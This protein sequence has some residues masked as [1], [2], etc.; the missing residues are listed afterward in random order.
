MEITNHKLV[1]TTPKPS[2][3]K[4]S[5]G[6]LVGPPPPPPPFEVVADAAAA[7]VDEGMSVETMREAET[8]LPTALALMVPTM[9]VKLADDM[10][11]ISLRLLS[12]RVASCNQHSNVICGAED[13]E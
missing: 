2:A 13:H 5:N 7:V 11:S 12:S 10:L 1:K 8:L 6:E 4:N 3:T 9:L